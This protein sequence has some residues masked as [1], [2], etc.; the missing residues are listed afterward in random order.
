MNID[1]SKIPFS[2]FGSYFAIS[3][4]NTDSGVYI[5]DVHGGDECPSKL[6][7]IEL[8]EKGDLQD[9]FIEGNETE[10]TIYNKYDKEKFIS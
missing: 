4:D 7:K 10:L 5:R 2:R 6:F 9:F 8:T 3:C 1:I